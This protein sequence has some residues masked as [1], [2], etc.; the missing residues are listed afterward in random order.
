MR[1]L[2]NVVQIVL[3]AKAMLDSNALHKWYAS[4]K[5]KK[6]KTEDEAIKKMFAVSTTK[7]MK[8][9]VGAL[10]AAGP[11]NT[12]NRSTAFVNMCEMRQAINEPGK[13]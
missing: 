3:G 4:R 7:S 1:C 8:Q 10:Q 6:I 5:S 11:Q 2:E 13:N 9:Y 12:V